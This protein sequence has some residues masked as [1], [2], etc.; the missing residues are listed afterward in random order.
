MTDYVFPAIQEYGRKSFVTMY[1]HL[2]LPLGITLCMTLFIVFDCICNIFAEIT[3]FA[4]RKF[5]DDFW[6]SCTVDEFFKKC[7]ILIP[8]F[9]QKYVY[10]ELL[11]T[12]VNQ[13]ISKYI[14]LLFASLMIEMLMLF[15][16][17][18][19][20]FYIVFAILIGYPLNRLLFSPLKV[21]F[22]GK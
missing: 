7:N 9:L 5:Y 16:I 6:N 22:W 8:A 4:D 12:G 20:R 11:K 3:A 13:T 19:P 17:G 1:L 18:V 2:V 21:F 10:L 14:T 15:L